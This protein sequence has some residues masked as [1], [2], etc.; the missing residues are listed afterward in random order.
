MTEERATYIVDS[1]LAE[2]EPLEVTISAESMDALQAEANQCGIT[3]SQVL[4]RLCS[5]L[6]RADL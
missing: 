4:E 5:T 1:E 6:N 3:V 2:P